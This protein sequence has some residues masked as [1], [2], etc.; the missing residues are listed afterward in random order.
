MLKAVAAL[1]SVKAASAQLLAGTTQVASP[2]LSP[3]EEDIPAQYNFGYSITD[4][5]TGD[6][7]ARQESRDGDVVTGSYSVQDPDGR[8]RT[9]TY[10]ADAVHG[11]QA[12]VTYDGE[13]GPVAIPIQ[14]EPAKS[15]VVAASDVVQTAPKTVSAVHS[16]G[17][18]PVLR[19]VVNTQQLRTGFPIGRL[20]PSVQNAFPIVPAVPGNSVQTIPTT[21]LQSVPRAVAPKVVQAAPA[22]PKVRDD[23][24]AD[25]KSVTDT[26]PVSKVVPKAQSEP[27]EQ[28]VK[29]QDLTS[30]VSI[31]QAL[32]NAGN[33]Q[34][35][36]LIS[37]AVPQSIPQVH[38]LRNLFSLQQ[39]LHHPQA[40]QATRTV[41][42]VQAIRTTTPLANVLRFVQAPNPSHHLLALTPQSSVQHNN[43]NNNNILQQQDQA[44]TVARTLPTTIQ[45]SP[46]FDLS[47]FQFVSA[48]HIV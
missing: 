23:A 8:I 41:P 40:L 6:S 47:N 45:V 36:R 44:V 42:V 18:E 7:K 24:Q 46:Q 5:D 19:T 10:T 27:T 11:F 33:V 38:G 25:I 39:A 28:D 17:V 34:P 29:N 14:S 30:T 15:V 43:N 3:L 35:F 13:E 26:A 21:V 12:K 16:I 32:R 4:R 48:G 20:V 9:V 37:N 1:M 2:N 22:V 31:V